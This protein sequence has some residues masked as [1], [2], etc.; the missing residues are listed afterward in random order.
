MKKHKLY[1]L[2]VLTLVVFILIAGSCFYINVPQKE[3]QQAVGD[4]QS[5][6]PVINTFS[7]SPANITAGGSSTLSWQVTG[8]NTVSIGPGIGNVALSGSTAVSPG[9]G[10]AYL[11]TATNGSGSV[12]AVAQVSVEAASSP[13]SGPGTSLPVID[14][15]AAN[16]DS[17][18]VGGSSTLGWSVS[19]VISVTISPGIGAVAPSGNKPISPGATTTYTLTATNAAGWRSKSITVTVSTI[20]L[21]KPIIPLVALAQFEDKTWVLEQYGQADNPENVLAGKE[22]NARF[23]SGSDKVSG[24]SGC[25]SYSA[26]YQRNFNNITVS[27]LTGTMMLCMAPAGIMQQESAFK[28]ALSGAQSCKIVNNKLEIICTSDRILVFHPK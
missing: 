19:N 17:I 2:L 1:L 11:L 9:V 8:A 22:L 25:N 13:P 7:A 15:F 16:P 14:S 10:T 3:G 27:S 20:K 12:T 24:T 21:F 18:L 26:N 5:T 23:D 4:A 28:N 6:L